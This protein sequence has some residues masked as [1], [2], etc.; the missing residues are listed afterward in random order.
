[1]ILILPLTMLVFSQFCL[2][3]VIIIKQETIKKLE[4]HIKELTK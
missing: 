1:M 3:M 4:A 2:L